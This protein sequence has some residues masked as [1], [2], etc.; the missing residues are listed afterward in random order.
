MLLLAVPASAHPA[1]LPPAPPCHALPLLI[2]L[3]SRADRLEISAA[4]G[5]GCSHV[6]QLS[7]LPAGLLPRGGIMAQDGRGLAAATLR[8]ATIEA[9]RPMR[10][11]IREAAQPTHVLPWR[12]R[13]VR[14]PR[15]CSRSRAGGV[16]ALN[17]GRKRLMRRCST[18]VPR[19]RA[20]PCRDRSRAQAGNDSPVNRRP[21]SGIPIAARRWAAIGQL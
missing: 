14:S 8:L 2:T 11:R 18:R 1:S 20:L 17:R 13:I 5:A 6:K 16:L 4:S 19:G 21:R 10:E 9:E 3:S 7:L 15:R 12:R